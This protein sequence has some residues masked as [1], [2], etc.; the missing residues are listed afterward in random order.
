MNEEKSPVLRFAVVILTVFI[1][2]IILFA[3]IPGF[4]SATVD[5]KTYQNEGAGWLHFNYNNGGRTYDISITSDGD[6]VTINQY[7]PYTGPAD[8]MIVYA[9]SNAVIVLQDGELYLIGSGL[10]YLGDSATVKRNNAG[11]RIT[12]GEDNAFT[13]GA[14]AWA[15]V[16]N[17]GGAYAFYPNDTPIERNEPHPLA[18]A[19]MFAGIGA[20]NEYVTVPGIVTLNADMGD[21]YINS[22]DWTAPGASLDDIS[23]IPF[24]PGIIPINPDPGAVVPMVAHPGAYTDGDWTYNLDGNNAI[25]VS[26][27]IEWEDMGGAI[28]DIPDTVGGYPVKQ[29]GGG[30]GPI[31]DG[32]TDYS[33]T[34]PEGVVTIYDRAFSGTGSDGILVIPSTVTSIGY[35]AF[36]GCRFSGIAVL[37]DAVPQ[38][39]TFRYC[40]NVQGVLNLGSE[41]WSQP[42]LYGLY[43]DVPVSSYI[44]SV[45]YIADTGYYTETYRLD[46]SAVLIRLIP[47]MLLIGLAV[48]FIHKI[49]NRNEFN[50][51]GGFKR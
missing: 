31:F 49:N 26:Y 17:K 39:D 20:Y 11:V 22:V 2:A 24:N 14:P 5:V 18:S 47:L 40:S 23:I 51:N 46:T 29:I 33:Y 4:I 50:L 42:N 1:S 38:S 12:D 13:Y 3:F 32:L 48:F 7:D 35:E 28:I 37:G 43:A 19:G 8:D 9:D 15:Y 45:G 6:N 10:H 21:D 36:S 27:L 34:I 44:A 16:P 41:D 30:E 25:L